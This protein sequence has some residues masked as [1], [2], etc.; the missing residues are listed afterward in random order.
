MAQK[1]TL[2]G[3]SAYEQHTQTYPGTPS[4]LNLHVDA[5][6]MAIQMHTETNQAYENSKKY[7]PPPEEEEEEEVEQDT[8]GRREWRKAGEQGKEERRTEEGGGEKEEKEGKDGEKGERK[9]KKGTI[10]LPEHSNSGTVHTWRSSDGKRHT[11][12]IFW[13]TPVCDGKHTALAVVVRQRAQYCHLGSLQEYSRS[14]V[15]KQVTDNFIHMH[16]L[17]MIWHIIHM[18]Q[19]RQ[20]RTTFGHI[21]GSN[22][23][24]MHV[25]YMIHI[26]RET[27]DRHETRTH[28][29]WSHDWGQG[30]YTW[31]SDSCAVHT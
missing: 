17:Y 1:N 14:H 5:I 2:L 20:R 12:L 15:S 18:I 16:L 6:L 25:L 8:E 29:A 27:Y 26:A 11:V 10:I 30:T 4:D 7:T 22:V 31:R 19:L 13:D 9:R 28:L 3:Q 21:F 24:H 23:I